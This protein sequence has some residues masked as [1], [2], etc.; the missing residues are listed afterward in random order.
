MNSG[1]VFIRYRIT[2]KHYYSEN[3]QKGKD[4]VLAISLETEVRA[5]EIEPVFYFSLD[6][7]KIRLEPDEQITRTFQAGSSS[8][9]DE[10]NTTTKEDPDNKG[11]DMTEAVTTYTTSSSHY[12]YQQILMRF[13]PDL[14][15]MKEIRSTSDVVFKIYLDN[16][17]LE[18]PFRWWYKQKY[19]RYMDLIE[20]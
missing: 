6:G 17:G 11:E 14:S 13:H 18:I 20:G 10:T 3:D 4:Y 15:L 1:E 16:E 8:S 7:K 9:S 5:Y 12:T 2:I 19:N